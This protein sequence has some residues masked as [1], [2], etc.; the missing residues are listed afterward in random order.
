MSS[1]ND[2]NV[3]VKFTANTQQIRQMFSQMQRLDTRVKSLSKSLT[4]LGNDF[5]RLGSRFDTTNSKVSKLNKSFTSQEGKQERVKAA[6]QKL[7]KSMKGYNKTTDDMKKSTDKGNKSLGFTGLAFGF[8]A[9]IAGFAASRIKNEF[10][11]VLEETAA[12]ISEV[13]RVS[14]FSDTGIIAGS[15]NLNG[16]N[17]QMERVNK[18]AQRFGIT[19]Q[20]AATLLKAVEKAAPSNIDTSALGDVISGFKLLENEVDVSQLTSDFATIAANF[21][22]LPLDEVADQAFAFSKATKLSF[23][24]GSKSIGFAAQA[25]KSLNTDL[26]D[27]LRTLATVVA[28]VPGDR[29]TA[30]RSIRRFVSGITDPKAI[31]LLEDL[32]IEVF[33][34]ND[35]F[36]GLERIIEQTAEVYTKL[37]SQ[38]QRAAAEFIEILGLTEN[39]KTGFLSF[40]NA[41]KETRE[42][43]A[44]D[45]DKALG[46]F[47]TAVEDQATKGEAVLNRLKNTVTILK[48]EFA[49]G[50]FPALEEVN[51][52]F[53]EFLAD[54]EL[55]ETIRA[56]GTAI[57][58]VLVFSLKTVVPLIKGFFGIFKENETLIKVVATAFV[59]LFAALSL[60]SAGGFILGFYFALIFLH[61]RLSKRMR[62]LGK[63]AS[64]ITRIYGAMTRAVQRAQ[65]ALGNFFRT[66]GTAIFRGLAT[67]LRGLG[68][69][70]LIA[71]AR[72]G[73]LFGLAFNIISNA[74]IFVG[75]FVKSLFARIAAL[76]TGGG[77]ASGS[78]FGAAYNAA[79]LAIMRAGA[80][81]TSVV[82]VFITRF[83]VAGATVGGAFGGAFTAASSVVMRAAAWLESVFAAMRTRFLA[84]GALSGGIFGGAFTG[85]ASAIMRAGAWITAALGGTKF[86][87]LLAE[88]GA[89]AGTIFGTAMAGAIGVALA[90]AAVTILDLLEERLF[91]TSTFK[92]I[93]E[94][95]GVK[96]EDQKSAGDIF[97]IPQTTPPFFD[98]LK[99]QTF[100]A[101]GN[102]VKEKS[103]GFTGLL[104][105]LLRG[106]NDIGELFGI[107]PGFKEEM[108]PVLNEAKTQFEDINTNVQKLNPKLVDYTTATE[109]V[110]GASGLL[111]DNVLKQ[112]IEVIKNINILSAMT[113]SIAQVNLM[114]ARLVAEGNRAA[115]KLASLR[116]SSSGKF[117]I[118]DPGISA[119]DR[120]NIDRAARD[121]TSTRAAQTSI[122][123]P[124]LGQ[125]KEQNNTITINPEII[126]QNAQ[127]LDA[128]QLVSLISEEFA[129]TLQKNIANISA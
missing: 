67:G 104:D 82:N 3:G 21:P 69:L 110:T 30:G 41:T 33:D 92:R 8:I 5:K 38:N 47:G 4:K 87:L 114:F 51:E 118:T 20:D 66:A 89:A 17:N 13:N 68:R 93:Q 9:G 128:R 70:F 11:Q 76:F 42:A 58:D 18:T 48:L 25:A 100:D 86:N 121:L 123:V 127:G 6:V 103:S 91:G 59:G 36:V 23:S 39:A 22:E 115:G 1:P 64:I 105:D 101:E 57:G 109:N 95:L 2:V 120:S 80:W 74:F 53:K 50:L 27:L 119:S 106:L 88:R 14:L 16:F 102:L 75:G 32:G 108:P 73:A 129:K 107:P 125:L 99:R 56:F 31:R 77:A 96:P 111:N 26:D 98:P 34:V 45:F 62:V 72:V 113:T 122:A 55:L 61:E 81:I 24:A 94:K 126:I 44:A 79:V 60:V 54:K 37:N 83:A 7:S 117:S 84:G 15:V 19:V 71:G 52:V 12:I 85:A 28:A 78:A 90:A 124:T 46:G 97:G 40:A 29:G 116:V 63:D 65:L 10:I 35:K 112:I 43:L 49:Q